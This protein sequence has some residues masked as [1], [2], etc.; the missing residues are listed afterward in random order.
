MKRI[1][2]FSLFTCNAIIAQVTDTGDNVGIGTTTPSYKLDV[3]GTVKAD[4]GILT[5]VPPDG[6]VFAN[7]RDRENKSLIFSAG[8]LVDNDSQS[9]TFNYYE[10][11]VSN[12]DPK[13]VSYLAIEDRNF[14]SR[15]RFQGVTGGST[16]FLL[17]GKN[18]TQ[19]FYVK[20]DGNSNVFM[21]L[22]KANSRIVI[23]GYGDYLPEHKLV[24]KDGSALIEGNI[25]T[26]NKIGIGV[27]S[28]EIPAD[29]NLAIAGRIIS[30]EVKVQLKNSGWPDFVFEKDYNLPTLKEVEQHINEK[31][32]LQDIPSAK[33][34]ASNGILLGDMHAKLLQKIE[35]LTLYT[36][37][38]QKLIEA[39]SKALKDQ[40][41]T[42]KKI[43]EKLSN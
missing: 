11:P 34:V 12:L 21:H 41:E 38:Q 36:I 27:T 25:I 40:A 6:S 42:I 5:S 1:L 9:R 24:V 3:V 29:Y 43:Q 17:F 22:P 8:T 14:N 23:A 20:D 37:E 33:D 2:L 18:Q 10:F 32:H 35:E 39:Q 26:N 16:D 31:G 7:Y 30:E 4:K 28:S 15:L 13:A 19:Y